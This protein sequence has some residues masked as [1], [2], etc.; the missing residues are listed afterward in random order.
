MIPT[1]PPKI[2]GPLFP[3]IRGEYNESKLADIIINKKKYKLD[4]YGNVTGFKKCL[5]DYDSGLYLE[6]VGVFENNSITEY[7]FGY[8]LKKE[9]PSSSEDEDS[10]DSDINSDVSENICV[11]Q[12]CKNN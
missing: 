3:L 4:E 1:Y 6:E 10:D 8:T 11:C 7:T 5:L 9:Q 12:V 2:C